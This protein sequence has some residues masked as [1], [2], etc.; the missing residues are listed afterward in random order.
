MDFRVRALLSI[1]RAIW[2]L[3]TPNLR[4]IAIAC[5]YPAISARFLFENRPTEEDCENVSLAETYSIA[6]FGDEVVIEFA[7][8][9][10]PC[11]M[12]RALEP[13]EEWVYLRKEP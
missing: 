5:S 9:W 13:G 3:V 1:Q 11:S 4:G 7:P 10:L 2:E 6:D 12:S 8:V